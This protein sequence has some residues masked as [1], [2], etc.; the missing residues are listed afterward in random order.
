MPSGQK[1][2]EAQ[3]ATC[4]QEA[5]C[6]GTSAECPISAPQPDGT[7]CL[8]K[9]KCR[10]GTCLP[11]C[12][13]QNY[14]SCMCDTVADACKR[15]CRYHLNDTCFPIEPHDILP[16]GTPCVHGFCNSVSFIA[17]LVMK[18]LLKES[19]SIPVGTNTF[20]WCRASARRLSKTL[21]ND[22]GTLSKS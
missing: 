22:S 2:R 8:E 1:C 6:T 13:T 11:F 20:C 19:K 5:K 21:W 14:Q 3:R 9:G 10:N 18:R 12:E 4:E 16:D 17:M 7:E 15:C